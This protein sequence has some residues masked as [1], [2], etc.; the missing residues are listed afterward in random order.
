MLVTQR[1]HVLCKGKL[2]LDSSKLL[3]CGSQPN[4]PDI[5]IW[6]KLEIGLCV[7]VCVCVC[8]KSVGFKCQQP[9]PVPK[10]ILVLSETTLPK[11]LCIQLG[12]RD[13]IPANL[14]YAEMI[15]VFSFQVWWRA[16]HEILSPSTACNAVNQRIR[17]RHLLKMM[18]L[19]A[20]QVPERLHAQSPFTTS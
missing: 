18:A 5:S 16:H 6:E 11:L 19:F 12:P 8:V 20:S 4:F 17:G 7:C 9:Q 1:Q 15:D 3:A 13:Q 14:K 10:Y 2:L